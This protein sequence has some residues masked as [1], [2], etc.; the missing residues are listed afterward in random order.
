MRNFN[1]TEVEK[2]AQIRVSIIQ[3]NNIMQRHTIITLNN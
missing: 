2:E 3:S 1:P